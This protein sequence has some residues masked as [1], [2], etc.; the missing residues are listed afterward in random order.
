MLKLGGCPKCDGC[1]FWDIQEQADMC[2]ACGWRPRNVSLDVQ[3]EVEAH[4]GQD[5]VGR[6]LKEAPKGKPPLNGWE[7]EKRRR[8]KRHAGKTPTPQALKAALTPR[9]TQW[10]AI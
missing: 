3:L 8:S 5:A 10:W 7:R 9:P 4:L 1:L 6:K 2:I